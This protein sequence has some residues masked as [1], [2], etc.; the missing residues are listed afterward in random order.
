[1]D[2]DQVAGQQTFF[3]EC[4]TQVVVEPQ[5]RGIGSPVRFGFVVDPPAQRLGD[6]LNHGRLDKSSFL[7]ETD[8]SEERRILPAVDFHQV[9]LFH[10]PAGARQATLGGRHRAHAHGG[11]GEGGVFLKRGKG[12]EVW[13][14]GTAYGAKQVGQPPAVAP[15]AATPATGGKV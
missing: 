6:V 2:V 4:R 10:A 7:R 5:D 9:E 15:T 14:W 11:E 3:D 1:M 12:A 8:E 13:G